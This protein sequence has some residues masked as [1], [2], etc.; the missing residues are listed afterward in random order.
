MFMPI[1][2]PVLTELPDSH[3]A[4]AI[5]VLEGT[6]RELSLSWSAFATAA[7]QAAGQDPQLERSLAFCA[8]LFAIE[9]SPPG[10]RKSATWNPPSWSDIAEEEVPFVRAL[11]DRFTDPDARARF[12]HLLWL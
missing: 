10:R 4:R 2:D 8:R 9:L 7:A 5:E 11:L 1:V 12:S 3:I 6:D